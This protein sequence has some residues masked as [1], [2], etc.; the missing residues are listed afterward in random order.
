MLRT[1]HFP[2]PNLKQRAARLDRAASG[3]ALHIMAMIMHTHTAPMQPIQYTDLF[4]PFGLLRPCMSKRIKS[5]MYMYRLLFQFPSTPNHH[6]PHDFR[7]P[8]WHSLL[9]HIYLPLYAFYHLV[10]NT[11]DGDFTVPYC[12]PPPWLR[13]HNTCSW[14]VDRAS[15]E[16]LNAQQ[17]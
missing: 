10:M 8:K 4:I 13:L 3:R 12:I 6:S 11:Q 15:P 5:A 9:I 2:F 7:L 16:R 1:Q 17:P 14:H